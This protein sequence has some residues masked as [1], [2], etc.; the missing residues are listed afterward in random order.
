[1]I[2]LT[3]YELADVL[4]VIMSQVVLC[5]LENKTLKEANNAQ[6]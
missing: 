3:K 1:M 6:K 2:N 5:K 4:F